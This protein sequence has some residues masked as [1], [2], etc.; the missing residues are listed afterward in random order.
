MIGC[1][2]AS[3]IVTL[4]GYGLF[5]LLDLTQFQFVLFGA[6]FVGMSSHL[7]LKRWQLLFAAII[8]VLF[9]SNLA[10]YFSGMGGTLGLMAFISVALINLV[11]I[12]RL[13]LN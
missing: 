4:I 8:F 12:K 5:V 10:H 1:V 6:S 13:P 11:N 3:C 7:R 2:R 9:Y